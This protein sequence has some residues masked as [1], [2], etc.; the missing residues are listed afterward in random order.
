MAV[1][2]VSPVRI[3]HT[4]ECFYFGVD[5]FNHN[6]PLRK[7]LVIRLLLF[8]QFMVFTCLYR[9]ETV[10]VV[11][12]YPMVS[13]IGVNRYRI[14]DALP[15]RIFKYFEIMLA[16]FGFLYVND[17]TAV[18]LNYDLRLQRMPFFFPE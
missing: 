14:A 15:N 3:R 2:A 6:T 4:L 12:F 5:M 17:L 18:P 9:Y 7:P 8:G 10:R 11:F 16:A 1:T 13:G